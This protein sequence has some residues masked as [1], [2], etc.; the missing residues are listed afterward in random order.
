[1]MPMMWLAIIAV[2]VAVTTLRRIHSGKRIRV[3]RARGA[4]VV[5]VRTSNEFRGGHA[6]GA[7]NMPLDQI[8]GLASKLDKSWPV[9]LCCAS[10]ARSAVAARML[11]EKGFD[12]FNA[13]SWTRLR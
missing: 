8:A 10:G 11:R 4:V 7:V 6:H 3:F 2:L 13:G 5:D 12:T 9:L 1:M